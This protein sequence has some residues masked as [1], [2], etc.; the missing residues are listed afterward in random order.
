MAKSYGVVGFAQDHHPGRPTDLRG[1][2]AAAG[3]E[4]VSLTRPA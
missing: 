4:A 3:R 2:L 1:V